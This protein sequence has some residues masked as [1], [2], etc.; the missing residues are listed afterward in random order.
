MGFLSGIFSSGVKTILTPI[1]VVKDVVNVIK[2]EEVNSTQK[3][4][5]S[6]VNDAAEAVDDLTEGDVL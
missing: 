6:A 5:E 1:A 3:L 4:I 2:D